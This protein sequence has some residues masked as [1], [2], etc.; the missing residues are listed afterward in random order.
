ME[1]WHFQ[2]ISERNFLTD[3]RT[4]EK[5]TIPCVHTLG[6]KKFKKL[7]QE[8][9]YTSTFTIKNRLHWFS[10]CS[11]V[12]LVLLRRGLGPKKYVNSQYLVC[13]MVTSYRSLRYAALIN[14][15]NSLETRKRLTSEFLKFIR[16]Y[17]LCKSTVFSKKD[18]WA[19]EA[20]PCLPISVTEGRKEGITDN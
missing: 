15:K 10:T 13:M 20:Q 5:I 8:V 17:F 1:F 19:K 9:H 7:F 2:W 11:W 14:F 16:V 4:D 12:Y 18:I 6:L 3:E